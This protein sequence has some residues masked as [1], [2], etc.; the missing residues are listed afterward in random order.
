M[1]FD[2]K[3]IIQTIG[4]FGLFAVVFAESGL[5]FG[6]VLPG[7]S[8]LVT[9]GLLATQG[10][11]NIGILIASLAF[12]AVL[13]DTVGYWSGKKFGR[14][15]FNKDGSREEHM[16]LLH[17]I[18]LTLR[19]K[20]HIDTASNFYKVHGKKTIIL[21]RFLPYVRTFAPIV[22]GIGR[23]E[24]KDFLTY[25][26]VGGV[27][28]SG[29]MLLIGFFLGNV[30]PNVDKYLIPIIVLIVVVSF[31]PTLIEHRKQIKKRVLW[32]VANIF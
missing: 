15:I 28:W 18:S 21:A 3:Q 9:A 14:R 32:L 20:K 8:L 19:D 1:N 27:F 16:S 23:M 25:N 13:G 24:Y 31:I 17:K 26:V 2:L 4:Y 6:F 12:A 11:F 10:Y 29:L 5:F 30:I 7:D 22:A